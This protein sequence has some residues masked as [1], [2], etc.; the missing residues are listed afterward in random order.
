MK[1]G[2]LIKDYRQTNNCSM[3]DF[4]KKSRLSKSYVSILERNN[5]PSTNKPPIPSLETIKAVS[6]AIGKDFNDVIALLDGNQKVLLEDTQPDPF[7]F[8]S[9]QLIAFPIIGNIAA[10]YDGQA[11][12]EVTGEYEYIPIS[13]LQGRPREDFLV[14]RVKGDSMYP[15][16]I[17]GD[18][19]LVLR[20]TSVDSGN[21]AVV[22]YN[23]EDATVK[24]VKYVYGEEWLE[25]VPANPE[26]KPKRIE[27]RDLEQCR[28]LG[29][30]TKLIRDID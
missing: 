30:V 12:E 1:L 13:M 28:V 25:L 16:L 7:P 8:E 3:D 22:L 4:A 2:D 24:R 29:R 17:E 10:G 19:V 14:L 20:S 6:L 18:R 11:V 21:T 9:E 26:F 5:N 15:K 27:G 23:G